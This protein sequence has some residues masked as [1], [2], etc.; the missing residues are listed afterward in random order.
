[1]RSR[2]PSADSAVRWL[3]AIGLFVVS[4]LTPTAA[5]AFWNSSANGTGTA[6][7]ATL[8]A[9]NVTASV[10]RYA[11]QADLTWSAPAV[12][13]GMS[14]TGYVVTRVSGGV[15]SAA[16]GSSP[17]SPLPAAT[18]SCTDVGVPDGEYSYAVTALVGS[19]TTTGASVEPVVVAADHAPPT[20]SL[21]GFG[22]T[23]TLLEK[24]SGDYVL[25]YRPTAAEGGSIRISAHVTDP[26][27]GPASATFPALAASGWTHATE[28]VSSSTGTL[29]ELVYASQPYA[30]TAGAA[31][32]APTSVVGTDASGNATST[33]VTFAP[34]ATPPA[35]AV[36]TANGTSASAVG[37]T[38][39]S[40]T[41]SFSL[42][43]Y[44]P[45]AE[46]ATTT[47]SGLATTSLVREFAPL[48]NSVCGTFDPLTQVDI[49]T[50][51]PVTQ[52]GLDPG[53]YRYTASGTDVV[54]NTASSSTTVRL[55][56]TA[57]VNGVLTVNG[58]DG[59][60][61][62]T[63]SSDTASPWSI[64]RT[65]FS[66]PET[67]PTTSTLT[68][69]VGTLSAGA[70]SAYAAP[71]TVGTAF[72][73][74]VVTSSEP[75]GLATGCYQYVLTGRNS[76]NVPSTLTTT[77]KLDTTA[78]TGGALTVNSTVASSGGSTSTN[79]TGSFTVSVLTAMTDTNSG[80]ASTVLTR[81]WAPSVG[82]VCGTFD[83]STTAT[84]TGTLP[85]AQSALAPGC[86]RYVLTGTSGVG[87]TATLTTT[88]R[89]DSTGPVGGALT[90]NGVN[91]T[92]AGTT[93]YDTASPW[94]IVRTAM[95]D[96]ETD[97]TT[98]TLTRAV[99]T[100][101]ANACSAFAAATTVGTTFTSG[102]VTSAEPSGLT[103]GCYQ[104][105]LTGRNALSVPTA[106]TTTVKLDMSVPSG[107][108]LTVNGTVATGVGSVSTRNASLV[109]PFTVSVLTHYV[110]AQSGM[111]SSTLVRTWAPMS[112]GVCGTFDPATSTT[113]SGTVPVNQVVTDTGCYRYVLTGMNNAGGTASLTTTVL[114]DLSPPVGGAL[115]VNGVDGDVTAT[116]SLAKA[117]GWPIARTAWTDPESATTTTGLTR[118]LAPYSGGVCGTFSGTLTVIAAG[119]TTEGSLAIGCY[120]YVL[121][122]TNSATL[123]S[124][125]TTIVRLDTSI[126]TGGGLTVNAVAASA[127][128]TTSN[129]KTGTF[130]VSVL[131]AMADT[132]SGMAS[133]VL[134]RTFAPVAA[135]VCGTFDPLTTTTI[136]GTLPIS[137]PSM[138]P[139]CYRYV[140]TGT[141]GVGG[142]ATL[143]TTVRTDSTA[144]VGSLTVNDVAAGTTQTNSTASGT[145]ITTVPIAIARTDYTDPETT[146]TSSVLTRTTTT[147]AN[148]VCG[149]TF[150]SS[151]IVAVGTTS[152]DLTVGCWRYTLVGTNSLG[153]VST[154][155]TVVAVDPSLPAG[156]ALT[157]NGVAATAGGSSSTI[158]TGSTFS[159]TVLTNFTDGQ[160]GMASSTVVRT[161]SPASG[162]GC[163][164][165]DPASATTIT[166]TG[167]QSFTGSGCY[168]YV[169]T[170]VNGYGGTSSLTTTIRFGP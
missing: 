36:L 128:G 131:T 15:S 85:I 89:T 32:P 132:N 87:G 27:T 162:P 78:P 140:L 70:C 114:V 54:G 68:R 142:T 127:A 102:T 169:L 88:V 43:A 14:V 2:A 8:P 38:S 90:A 113:I 42:T 64:S 150:G 41:A 98:M 137:Q 154:V 155:I 97:P 108:A 161:T 19:W 44:T 103:T 84:I 160:S 5:W 63:L 75:G 95:S 166:G 119:T 29:P 7:V 109:P 56:P 125:D 52:T 104:Y 105:V 80:M 9:P 151:T 149:A 152:Q 49:A 17:V 28:T 37:T 99:G 82:G 13:S 111:A 145:G 138:A 146:M 136:S 55:D 24:R 106:V 170:G 16:C 100:L 107:G 34:D 158:A 96:P 77:V 126:P 46:A 10:E 26:E 11:T 134:T 74:G 94:D 141:N 117:V 133:T 60:P 115:T 45:Y 40:S 76:L 157:V 3:V 33:T 58:T 93:S 69:S 81:T 143:T 122:G 61:T 168:R 20:V 116:T 30:Y 66:D 147:L 53:C 135:N 31:A 130:T 73:S 62:E 59:A 118:Q 1:M 129:D 91:G 50:A 18:L 71:T 124:T 148:G 121:T 139:G 4:V 123:A 57:P 12:L 47:A 25:F 22:A 165:F 86:Y 65:A 112:A 67:N 159:L 92:T 21:T 156:G 51:M 23:N 110:D 164:A 79:T 163:G 167:T 120:R 48:V 35:G 101:S 72:T 39:A 153:L 144:P 83:S 6:S